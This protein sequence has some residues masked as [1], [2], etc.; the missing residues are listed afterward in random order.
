VESA[1]RNVWSLCA[2][3]DYKPIS[4]LLLTASIKGSLYNN[5]ATVV[6]A[7]PPVEA[8]LKVRYTHKHFTLGASAELYG[9]TKWSYIH[10]AHLMNADA[11]SYVTREIRTVGAFVD[12]NLFAEWHLSRA[13]TLFIEGNNL[14]NMKAERW[15][16]YREMG[17][18]FTVGAKV[19]F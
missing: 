7:L 16:F 3:V 10:D 9:T 8:M 6:D 11:P 2:A 19:Q 17:A 14:A 12:V 5:F 4:Q 1:K 18:S 15:A 13:C